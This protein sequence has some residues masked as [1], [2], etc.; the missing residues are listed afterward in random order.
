MNSESSIKNFTR[1]GQTFLHNFR[2]VN[3]IINRVAIFCFVFFV[4]ATLSLGYLF[5]TEY[6]RYLMEQW[7]WAN[8]LVLFNDT[9]KQEFINPNGS[10]V[11]VFSK[12]ILNATFVNQAIQDVSRAGIKAM[13]GG[14]LATMVCFLFMYRWLRKRGEQQAE[15]KQLRGDEIVWTLDKFCRYETSG[16]KFTNQYE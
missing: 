3:Q 16:P 5:T 11:K 8:V 6:Q 15:T 1:G 9:A 7:G 10:F 14:F 12:Q 13:T 4:L 2:M